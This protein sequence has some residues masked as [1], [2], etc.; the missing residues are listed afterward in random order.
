VT[1][2]TGTVYA[3]I[4][5]RDGVTRYI[6]Q[7]KKQPF[8]ERLSGAYAP[9]VRAWLSELRGAG[10]APLMLAVREGVATA[11]LLTAERE[12]IT[13]ILLA[14]GKLLNEL[15][16]A[17]GRELLRLRREAERVE[18]DRAAW[19]ELADIA[20]DML[21]GPLPP[22]TIPDVGIPGITWL[23]MSTT[24]TERQERLKPLLAVVERAGL[25]AEGTERRYRL[26]L[27]L[28]H[29]KEDAARELQQRAHGAW[30]ATCE[31]GGDR[32]T[33][34]LD[35][36]VSVVMETPY[37]DCGEVS[38]HLALTVWYMVA[39]HPWRHLAEIAGLAPDDET[40]IAWAG[41]NADVREALGFLANRR[42]R[43]LE[44]LPHRYYG[45]WGRGPGH[46]LAAVAAAYSGTAPEA[47]RDHVTEVLGRMAD[48]HEL[49]QPMA[50]LLLRLDPRTLDSVF[51]R[52]IAADIDRDLDIAAGT[53]GRVLQALA[54]RIGHIN[55]PQIRRAID[56]STRAL[57][58]VA[59]SDYRDW[60]GPSTLDALVINASLVR[61]GLAV[62]DHATPEE[63]LAEVR[64]LWTPNLEGF[65]DEDDA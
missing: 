53:S 40:F 37:T 2:T 3:L 12:E 19:R 52:D 24:E 28:S 58:V 48:D 8:T 27:S 1:A 18:A 39:V 41:R 51:G 46:T 65:T 64:A 43:A 29:A 36:N 10:L 62:P 60:S 61:A 6:G 31:R 47:V 34:D 33:K 32:F 17:T 7:T 49:T 56:R 14:G 45:T 50:D 15:S 11:E 16:T 30:G 25:L 13:C 59:L 63:Y 55:D 26:W 22:G 44:R 5:P 4:D 57:P 23:Y 42:E 9:R 54:E 38:R 21:G 20:L 35:L